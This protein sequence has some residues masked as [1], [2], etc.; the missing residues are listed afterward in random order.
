MLIVPFTLLADGQP[1]SGKADA[2]NAGSAQVAN[3]L[4]WQSDSNSI[5]LLNVGKVVWRLNHDKA[6]GK[7][8]FHPLAT[9]DGNVLTCL[10]PADHRWH[11]ALWFS[12][13]FINGLN[14]WEESAKTGKSEGYTDLVDI[15]IAPA[16]DFSA[17]IEMSLNYHPPQQAA[18]LSESRVID[19]S[20]PQKDGS[21]RL[22][23]VSSFTALSDVVLGRTPIPG[24]T[25]GVAYGGYAG[26]S[27]RMA[28]ELKSWNFVDSEGRENDA[29]HGKKAAWLDTSGSCGD[30]VYGVAIMS[31]PANG[32]NLSPWYLA[33]G[34]PYFSP[35]FLFDSDYKLEK[36]KTL[37]L[38]YRVLVHKG[39]ADKAML[40]VEQQNFVNAK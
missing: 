18:V 36:D 34:M 10:R 28:K 8:Y 35:A 15:M 17:R 2:V 31:H 27:I 21:Y 14:Y 12:W 11:R 39:A 4:A 38:K 29:A 37:V 20:A 16:S 19:V 24:E 26:L 3:E 23:W 40:D 5:A 1:V 22:T 30:G 13:K 9:V 32:P 6:E 25:N 7:P 33:K